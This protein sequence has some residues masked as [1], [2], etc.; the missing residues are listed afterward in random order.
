MTVNTN[1]AVTG[2]V[3]NVMGLWTPVL[4]FVTPGD[5]SV[6]YNY[7]VGTW[8]KQGDRVT[9]NFE[10]S[11]STF[12]FGTASGALNITGIPFD[13]N[14][15]TNNNSV[16]SCVIQGITK[17][18]YTQFSPL[19]QAGSNTFIRFSASGSGQAISTIAAADMPSGGSVIIWGTLTY[20]I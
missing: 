18:S 20:Q 17:A 5:L 8:T 14:T 11:T 16:G 6:A 13:G 15:T 7:R 9:V 3:S 1:G 2:V 10:I 19:I 4:T 12:T